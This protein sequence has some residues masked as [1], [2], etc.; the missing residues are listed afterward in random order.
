MAD[1]ATLAAQDRGP[2][3][4]A[5]VIALLALSTAFIALRL[6][7]RLGVVKRVGND[8]YAIILAWV[9]NMSIPMGTGHRTLIDSS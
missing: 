1:T 8:D 9:S 4:L 3:V 6:V 2:T 5:V 7:S